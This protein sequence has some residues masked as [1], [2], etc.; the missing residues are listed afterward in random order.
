VR[1]AACHSE[2]PDDATFCGAC[3]RAL[4]TITARS[5]APAS[6]E[7]VAAA[8]AGP[9]TAPAPP[10]TSTSAPST[11]A[12]VGPAGDD[13]DRIFRPGDVIVG[14]YIVERQ[15]GRGGMG[16][17]YLA[18]DRVSGQRVAVKALPASL[19]R[20]RDIRER[21]VR[22]ARALAA[23][24]HPGI[25]PLVTF[26]QDGDER[27]LVMKYIA[28][29]SLEALLARVGVLP[30][31]RAVSIVRA[32]AEALDYAHARG[33]IHRDIKP[34][35]VLIADDGRVVI[36]DFGIARTSEGD[37]RVTET[38][39]LMGTPQ[40]MSPEQIVGATV[41]GRADL[42]ACGLVLHEMLTGAPPFDGE[43]TFDILRAHVEEAPI[44][45]V[46]ARAA[47]VPDDAPLPPGLAAVVARLLEKDP[48][49]RPA[50]GLALVA[51][52]DDPATATTTS[53][54]TP[55]S[56][57]A[58]ATMTTTTTRQR[59]T[60][61]TPAAAFNEPGDDDPAEL[62]AIVRPP[63][64]LPWLVL[65]AGVSLAGLAGLVVLA[66]PSRPRD[67]H[68]LAVADAGDTRFEEAVLLVRARVALDAGRLDDARIALETARELGFDDD[69]L[70]LTQAELRAA[71]ADPVGARTLLGTVNLAALDETARIRA[72]RL[73]THVD[74]PPPPPSPSPGGRRSRTPPRPK[75]P[76]TPPADLRQRPSALADDVLDAITG[77]TR[78]RVAACYTDH[79]V[80]AHVD[81]ADDDA[82]AGE[83]VLD[84][85]IAANGAVVDAT[86][87][88]ATVGEAR[89]HDC[90]REAV[91]AWR[92]PPFAGADDRLTHR[93][94]FR[95][96]R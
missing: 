24:D 40:Y 51:L 65:G 23:L 16:A 74:A 27:F 48:A 73:R 11:P 54:P 88:R 31:A 13:A 43:R 25:V 18:T 83:V 41:D 33:V 44:D 30:P 86:V 85:R 77:S 2:A 71:L 7:D 17:V 63:R 89:F 93:L 35:N 14:S 22:E 9:S 28:G 32:M 56:Q 75:P 70:R 67:A 52:L 20:E 62:A 58:R 87:L 84:V 47:V 50:T 26:A 37:R 91:M 72:E 78:D 19:A 94:A 96:R 10:A 79:V 5:H 21:F 68:A 15:L 4:R 57:P 8:D 6:A 64:A 55:S 36:V 60:S 82:P 49:A 38:G 12:S 59:A 34:G 95:T 66:P 53:R 81:E 92:F 90:V 29:E 42:Y 46:T 3:G 1:C 69:D 39:L 80:S 61:E 76:P 45:V